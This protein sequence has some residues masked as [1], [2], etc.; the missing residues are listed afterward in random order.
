[1]EKEINIVENRITVFTWIGV[2]L[3]I[4]GIGCFIY[5]FLW[6]DI[7]VLYYNEFG[8]YVGGVV[9]AL[10]SLS[11]ISF[12]YVAFLGQKLQLLHQKDDLMKS[13]SEKK[14]L[15]L[16][17]IQLKFETTFF[18]LLQAFSNVV[19][20]MDYRKKNGTVISLGKDCFR[21]FYKHF[22]KK[23]REKKQ[24]RYKESKTEGG[25]MDLDSFKYDSVRLFINDVLEC[26][27]EKYKVNQGDLTHYFR[28]L[29]NLIQ[30]VLNA[31]KSIE[32]D[33]YLEIILGQMSVYEIV[34]LYYYG[35]SEEGK[36]Y[37]PLIEGHGLLRYL[38]QNAAKLLVNR[39]SMSYS[40][41]AGARAFIVEH[42]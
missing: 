17:N 14:Q 2:A 24:Q 10:W 35:Q 13:E 11:A 27:S 1:M 40:Y 18:N 23:I 9:G 39:H 20:V 30:F 36:K 21:T 37:K 28:I 33:K 19:Q 6:F 38:D 8:D 32:K 25:G 26:F 31:D 5:P 34:F 15:K 12:V 7:R 4:G 22:V 16:D 29:F 42:D 41:T 3:A